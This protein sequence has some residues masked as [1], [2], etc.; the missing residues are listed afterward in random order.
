MS[1]ESAAAFIRFA[2]SGDN[3]ARQL[4]AP[5]ACVTYDVLCAAG[6]EAGFSFDAAELAA[7]FRFD[8][9]ARR[10]HYSCSGRAS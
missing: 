6:R 3:V 7:A 1:I 4:G 5:G 2:R 8:W 10:I 9:A